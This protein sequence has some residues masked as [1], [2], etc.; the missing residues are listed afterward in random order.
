MELRL[1]IRL[2]VNYTKLQTFGVTGVNRKKSIAFI[3]KISLAFFRLLGT[4][5]ANF[6][7]RSGSKPKI[8][9]TFGVKNRIW[10]GCLFRQYVLS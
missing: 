4:D 3:F 7:I 10:I 5:E 2:I 1:I 8:Y 6:P 9:H